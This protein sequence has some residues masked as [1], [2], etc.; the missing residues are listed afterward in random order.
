M[1]MEQL[2]DEIEVYI[3]NCKTAGV[4][5]GGSMI[6]VN[7]EE[8]L[9]MLEELHAQLPREL[10]EAR[11]VLR[12]KEAIIN[13]AKT[14]ADRIVKEAAKE[15]GTM[16]ENHEIVNMANIR[17]GEIMGEA[18]KEADELTGV[19]RENARAVQTGA[20]QYAQNMLEGLE[21]MY[22]SII[23][24]EQD[25]FEAVIDKL[26]EQHSQILADKQEIDMQLGAGGRT[27]RS[28]EQFEKKEE[29]AD[30]QPKERKAD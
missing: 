7:R 14:K 23:S 30:S 29:A 19:S 16:I 13:D 15:A 17:A 25:Y 3:D 1:T 9:A 20:L 4:L 12:T 5:S 27:T 8:L 6:K 11:Q 10:A 28:R 24:Q 21:Y 22:S 2:I 18:Q 26:R